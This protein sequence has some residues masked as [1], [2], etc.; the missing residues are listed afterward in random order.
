MSTPTGAKAL[1]RYLYLFKSRSNS[2]DCIVSA[3]GGYIFENSGFTVPQGVTLRFYSPHSSSLID[4]G[5]GSFQR[6]AAQAIPVQTVK[7]GEIC[8]NYLLSKYQGRHGNEDETYESIAK[9]VNEID[10]GRQGLFGALMKA[11][12]TKNPR[13]DNQE[14]LLLALGRNIGGSVLT[15]RN[16][17]D[18]VFGIK[19]SDAI[20]AARKEMPTLREFYCIFCRANM[21]GE[22]ANP[23][24]HVKYAA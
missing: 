9:G 10:M 16:R 13:A 20:A 14:K 11:G 15:V 3:H 17:F 19:L 24:G 2:V 12:D 8:C 21:L 5:L 1:G 18:V 6:A 4:P 23:D 7:G 22:D